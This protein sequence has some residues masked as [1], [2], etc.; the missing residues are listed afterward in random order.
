MVPRPPASATAEPDMPEKIML[1]TIL[2]CP[3]PPWTWPTN[4]LAK[5]NILSV[6]PPAFI[7]FPERI[8]NGIAIRTKESTPITILWTM[9][10]MGISEKNT[11]EPAHANPMAKAMGNRN[12]TRTIKKMMSEVNIPTSYLEN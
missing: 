3:N 1:A 8:N 4:P 5:E 12:N 11:S 2:A 6:I 9:I 7:K 10:I